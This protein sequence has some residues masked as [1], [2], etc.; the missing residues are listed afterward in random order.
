MFFSKVESANTPKEI[1]NVRVYLTAVTVAWGACLFGYDS[2][3]IGSTITLVGFQDD[4]GL[5][6]L[7]ASQKAAT[8]A[9][10]I[11]V[12]QAGAFFGAMFGFPLMERFGRK[13]ALQVA[14]MVFIVG[15]I[16]QT[17]AST[18]IALIYAGR[19]LVG[20]G[21]GTITAAAPVFIAEVSPPAIRGQLVGFYEIAY[22][23]G[24]VVGFWINYGLKQHQ[25]VTA[26]KTWRIPMAV[27]LIPS[28]ML[29]VSLFFI[30][31]TPRF[32]LKQGRTDAALSSLTFLRNLPA[33]HPYILEE[34][35]AIESQIE[36]VS[37]LRGEEER[38]GKWAWFKSYWYGIWR[39]IT[40]KG[41]RN[42]M[43][44]GFGMMMFQNMVGTNA[45]NY[46]AES[47]I[48]SAIGLSA[49]DGSLY[50][51][52]YGALKAVASVIFLGF[53]VDNVGRRPPLLVGGVVCALCMFYLGGYIQAAH[54][55]SYAAGALPSSVVKGGQAAV[56]AIFIFGMAFAASWNGLAWIICSE[57]YPLKIRGFCA[58]YT[59]MCQW[60]FQFIIAR[61]TPPMAAT[62]GAG[63]F[64]L[65]GSF[66]VLAVLFAWFFIPEL[67]G[68][69]LERMDALFGYSDF[70]PN[71]ELKQEKV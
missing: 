15:A 37:L 19:V 13:I 21:V 25:D 29:F 12:F 52:I 32:L 17:V 46:F 31:E 57:I 63:M 68:L 61:S 49:A 27:Q 51:G 67:K 2:S 60:L 30:R 33:D 4:F 58:C 44:L 56:A 48:F 50:T 65:F 38:D 23:V 53:L 26:R 1:Y 41:I 66:C 70:E 40:A 54:P 16:L 36:D 42:R 62:L 20:L 10:I 28:G 11:A 71:A 18:D 22:Q 35:A 7:P 14:T 9:N 34:V 47:T 45:I 3:Y 24:A 8:S 59:A 43:A 64:F 5:T 39:Y 6:G 55:K 69:T